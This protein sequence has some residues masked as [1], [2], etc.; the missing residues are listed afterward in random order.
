MAQADNGR[1][2]ADCS[3]H[4]QVLPSQFCALPRTRPRT[5]VRPTAS[6]FFRRTDG[7][8]RTGERIR[9]GR[10]ADDFRQRRR[11]RVGDGPRARCGLRPASSYDGLRAVHSVERERRRAGAGRPQDDAVSGQ[12][13][14]DV[15]RSGRRNRERAQP[16]R[17]AIFRGAIRAQTA[18]KTGTRKARLRR[19]RGGRWQGAGARRDL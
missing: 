1:V 19:M 11:A 9:S 16:G 6:A 18:G 8:E 4:P 15:F 3:K 7:D 13:A 12:G 5:I 17:H 10:D 14:R 2:A